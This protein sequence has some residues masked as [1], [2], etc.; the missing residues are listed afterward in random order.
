[1]VHILPPFLRISSSAA[2]VPTS[3]PA[4]VSQCPP[5]PSPA[6]HGPGVIH[7]VQCEYRNVNRVVINII[8]WHNILTNPS[9]LTPHT[10]P[11]THSP[12]HTHSSIHP[13]TH[14]TH[15]STHPP[16]HL[17]THPPTYSSTQLLTQ[18]THPYSTHLLIHTSTHPSTTHQSPHLYLIH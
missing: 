12:L 3:A 13:P 16:T 6:H 5:L 11:L 4:A 14:S 2:Q 17:L 1:M 10:Y 15:T 18:P 7:H 8:L 9:I